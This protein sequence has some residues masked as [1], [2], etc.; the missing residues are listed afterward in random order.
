MLYCQYA[1]EIFCQHLTQI[2]KQKRGALAV[3]DIEYLH[4]LRVGIRRLTNTLWVFQDLFPKKTYQK[5]KASL[6]KLT[7]VLGRARD[8]DVKIALIESYGAKSRDAQIKKHVQILIRTLAEERRESQEKVSAAIK[9]F[10]KEKTTLEISKSLEKPLDTTSRQQ[11]IKRIAIQRISS[12]IAQMNQRSHCVHKPQKVKE[13]HRLRI[14]VR[15][16]RYSLESFVLFYGKDIKPYLKYA[17][18]IQGALGKTHDLDVW[19]Q[20]L[21][22]YAS[23]ESRNIA[24]PVTLSI[25]IGDCRVLRN[26]SYRKFFRLWSNAQKDKTWNKCRRFLSYHKRT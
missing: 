1:Q 15:H 14:A 4:Q 17:K 11:K 3:R 7:K 10:E 5:H 24:F 6:K 9:E 25:L 8:Q 2:E 26:K 18:G 16:L 23:I 13:L 21:P 22:G 20:Q 12:R 19:I